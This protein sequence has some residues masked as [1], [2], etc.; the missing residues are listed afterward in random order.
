MRAAH[1]AGRRNWL[2]EIALEPI[3]RAL[4]VGCGDPHCEDA[5]AS[6]QIGARGV[7][8]ELHGGRSVVGNSSILIPQLH[9]R[10]N[11]NAPLYWERRGHYFDLRRQLVDRGAPTRG[12]VQ[13]P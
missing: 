7:E 5:I 4:F 3:A 10:N 2:A 1:W 13:F 11:Y 9:Y 12:R 6:G 8:N